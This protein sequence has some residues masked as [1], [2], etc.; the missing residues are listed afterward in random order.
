MS[1]YYEFNRPKIKIKSSQSGVNFYC[2]DIQNVFLLNEIR[3]K[4][5]PKITTSKHI[6][7]NSIKFCLTEL[8]FM[9]FI[10]V[11]CIQVFLFDNE[12]ITNNI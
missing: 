9:I 3:N 5:P 4:N 11:W 10:A 6:M 2:L 7:F 1:Y 12:N 8:D